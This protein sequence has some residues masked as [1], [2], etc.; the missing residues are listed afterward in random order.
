MINKKL[1]I[2]DYFAMMVSKIRYLTYRKRTKNLSMC[3]IRQSK[4]FSQIFFNILWRMDARSF[5][6]KV[7]YECPRFHFL[8]K[9]RKPVGRWHFPIIHVETV[10][11]M[12]LI[13]YLNMNIYPTLPVM[14]CHS[15]SELD[16]RW[17]E[18][19][20]VMTCISWGSKISFY[21]L[22]SLRK[23]S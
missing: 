19:V 17:P 11:S 1:Y 13:V 20:I 2:Y 10:S 16:I 15:M 9:M 7:Y 3:S 14:S 22:Y 12:F 23:M 4:N 21:S 5:Y 8:E 18:E 6:S